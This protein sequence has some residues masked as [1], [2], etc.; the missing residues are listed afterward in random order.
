MCRL[1]LV[2]MRLRTWSQMVLPLIYPPMAEIAGAF[3]DFR[4]ERDRF[5]RIWGKPLLFHNFFHSCGKL[6]GETL[7]PREGGDFSTRAGR[8]TTRP[9]RTPDGLTA[10]VALVTI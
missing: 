4:P 10:Y 5:A 9:R 2:S 1:T 7:R 6:R 8:P 3:A